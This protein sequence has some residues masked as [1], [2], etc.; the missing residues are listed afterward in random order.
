MK[1]LDESFPFIPEVRL[2]HSK[3]KCGKFIRRE[4]DMVPHFIDTKHCAQT[5]YKDGVAVVL[6]ACDHDW[7]GDA[8]LLCH[9]AY[10]AIVAHYAY[11]GEENPS[12]EFVAYGV[13]TI[14]KALFVAHHRWK[15]KKGKVAE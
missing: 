13:Q 10:H 8:A 9:E 7:H 5:W 4:F 11:L 2:F 14:S 15:I 6:F 3:R 12:E 1:A